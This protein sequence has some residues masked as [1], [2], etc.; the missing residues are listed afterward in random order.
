M[1]AIQPASRLQT[2][3]SRVITP[4]FDCKAQEGEEVQ[5]KDRTREKQERR[6]ED[7]K[8]EV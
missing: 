8:I 3:Q 2:S 1:A 5:R 7:T 4:K 6:G